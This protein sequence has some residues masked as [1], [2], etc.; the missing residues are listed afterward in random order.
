MKKFNSFFTGMCMI[1]FF[2]VN[3]YSQVKDIDGNTYKTVKIGSQ[4]WMA[5]NLKTTRL[6][7]N[8]KIPVVEN[9]DSFIALKT[10]AFCWYKNDTIYKKI[11]GGLYNWYSVKTGK[12]CPAGWHVPTDA[13]WLKMELAIGLTQE[14]AIDGVWDRGKE[15]GAKLKVLSAWETPDNSVKPSGF[16][17]L[18]GGLRGD[19]GSFMGA[20]VKSGMSFNLHTVFWS[21]TP[22]EGTTL[23]NA[24][25]AY[26][27]S[28][29][30]DNSI[31]RNLSA[32][33]RGH[34]IR[35]IKD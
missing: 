4:T 33:S 5:E 13:E 32:V 2:G 16:A 26:F 10:P 22:R 12:L 14:D 17:A 19:D 29:N 1:M 24:R 6:N 8:V 9:N 25:D 34:Y 15:H 35:C 3:A 31:E 30:K 28:V 7:D 18:P 21:S 11:Y 20:R 23:Q 27:R